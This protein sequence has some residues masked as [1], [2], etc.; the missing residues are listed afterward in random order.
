MNRDMI[1]AARM[2]AYR[3]GR[4]IALLSDDSNNDNESVITQITQAWDEFIT[5][6]TALDGAETIVG[7]IRESY[8]RGRTHGD[9]A[10]DNALN[11][12]LTGT[13]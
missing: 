5:Q 1:K 11:F 7:Y 12:V 4:T 13:S 9:D 2:Q 3:Y 6:F 8:E 10:L